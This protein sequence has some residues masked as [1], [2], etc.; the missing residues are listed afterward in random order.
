MRYPIPP[1]NR[2]KRLSTTLRWYQQ[3]DRVL[4]GLWWIEAMA[5]AENADSEIDGEQ[6]ADLKAALLGTV[7][8]L[9]VREQRD[10]RQAKIERLERVEGRTPEETV[11]YLSKAQ[12]MR[13]SRGRS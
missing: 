3:T 6:V 9:E 1:G 7:E 12:R 8:A 11:A 2:I 13:A 5:Y 10:A 4:R